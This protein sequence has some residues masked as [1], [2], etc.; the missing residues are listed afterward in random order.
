MSFEN[1]NRFVQEQI[2]L[3]DKEREKNKTAAIR[4]SDFEITHK[5]NPLKSND[6]RNSSS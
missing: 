3:L 5:S 2:S 4:T 6:I 1:W